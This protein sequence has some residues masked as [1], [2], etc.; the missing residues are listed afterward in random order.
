MEEQAEECPLSKVLQRGLL[1]T[2]HGS[3]DWPMGQ[4]RCHPH[5]VGGGQR[6]PLLFVWG[7]FQNLGWEVQPEQAVHHHPWGISKRPPLQR[8]LA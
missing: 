8:T 6:Q 2:P 1:V 3:C 7:G 5:E 4:W